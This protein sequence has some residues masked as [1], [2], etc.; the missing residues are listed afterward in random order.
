VRRYGP[1]RGAADVALAERLAGTDVELHWAVV[2][3]DPGAEGGAV[4]CIRVGPGGGYGA[5][6]HPTCER[7]VIVLSGTG[8]QVTADQPARFGASDF[9]HVP[10]GVGHG[11]SNGGPEEARLLVAYYGTHSADPAAH[12]P[13][14][15]DGAT[16]GG[17]RATGP[18]SWRSL[19]A[20]ELG[21]SDGFV[22]VRSTL[23][24]TAETA[25]AQRLLA[26]VARFAPGGTHVLHRHRTAGEAL[27]V[28]D[29]DACWHLGP[30]STATHVPA[31][32][33]TS[34]EAG[35]W[36]GLVNRGPTEATAVFFYLGAA[37]VGEDGYELAAA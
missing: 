3:D 33:L 10:A 19:P 18:I 22:G 30:R 12:Q 25:G 26:G 20:V 5:H 2:G 6:R 21:A 8:V 35:E 4:A 17:G 13:V 28:L 7:V 16:E 34:V 23:V 1:R 31:G 37:T 14:S 24:V 15:G 32:A 29:G 11:F 27:Y 36:H 9:L